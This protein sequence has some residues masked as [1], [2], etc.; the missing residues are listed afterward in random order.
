MYAINYAESLKILIYR[1]NFA[2]GVIMALPQCFVLS[3]IRYYGEA[4][5][6]SM[7]SKHSCHT[8]YF[9]LN[10]AARFILR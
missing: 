5:P 4:I 3:P 9:A 6:Q 1:G 7:H 8:S 2:Y 10:I